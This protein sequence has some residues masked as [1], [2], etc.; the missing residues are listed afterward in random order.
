MNYIRFW[1]DDLVSRTPQVLKNPVKVEGIWDKHLGPMVQYAK[2]IMNVEPAASFQ[3]DLSSLEL[4]LDHHQMDML[5]S[6]IFGFLD[7]V[8]CAGL[9]P[10]RNLKLE[11]LDVEFDPVNSSMIAFRYAGRDAGRKLLDSM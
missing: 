2:V 11:I 1:Q 3:V 9:S 4:K 10:L 7:V 5:R 6:A 8:M